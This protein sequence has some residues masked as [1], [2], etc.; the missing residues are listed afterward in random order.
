[1]RV[2][3][4][5]VAAFQFEGRNERLP[6]YECDFLDATYGLHGGPSVPASP[7]LDLDLD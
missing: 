3:V 2:T 5:S 7:A 6:I 1:M 4:D